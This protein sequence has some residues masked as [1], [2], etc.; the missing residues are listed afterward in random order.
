MYLLH[1]CV[2]YG[3]GAGSIF[4][5]ECLLFFLGMILSYWF[6]ISMY[7]LWGYGAGESFEDVLEYELV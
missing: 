2:I 7:L 5:C 1:V 3:C 6:Q 4:S